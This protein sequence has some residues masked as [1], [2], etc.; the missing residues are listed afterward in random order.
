MCAK[1]ENWKPGL[2]ERH[3]KNVPLVSPT[4]AL[5]KLSVVQVQDK[6]MRELIE[7]AKPG[8]VH[9]LPDHIVQYQ[10]H[11]APRCST[12]RRSSVS[13]FTRV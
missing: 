5:S 3:R 4:A 9:H 11:S 2:L 7:G 6:H 10:V 8:V 13:A 1:R 12:D